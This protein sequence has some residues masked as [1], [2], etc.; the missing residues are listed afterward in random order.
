MQVSYTLQVSIAQSRPEDLVKMAL[1]KCQSRSAMAIGRYDNYVLR[2][3]GRDE[4]FLGDYPLSQFKVC[5][6]HSSVCLLFC[7]TL[8]LALRILDVPVRKCRLLFNNRSVKFSSLHP[9]FVRF[10]QHFSLF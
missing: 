5:I 10:V 8:L 9:I 4:Y 3:S 7:L 6:H 1:D 2:V